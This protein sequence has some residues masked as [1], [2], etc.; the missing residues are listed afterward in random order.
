M[1]YSKVVLNRERAAGYPL[2][3][4]H[5]DGVKNRVGDMLCVV[6]TETITL[7]IQRASFFYSKYHFKIKSQ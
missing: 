7:E 6:I 5:E 2:N 4:I 3:G 1:K